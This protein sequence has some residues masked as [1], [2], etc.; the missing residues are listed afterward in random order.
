[1]A[2]GMTNSI[3]ITIRENCVPLKNISDGFPNS[4]MAVI[5]LVVK[6]KLTGN[7]C[8]SDPRKKSADEE[9]DDDLWKKP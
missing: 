9:D 7:S 3:G 8:I 5:K 6:L 4:S 2:T 1:M